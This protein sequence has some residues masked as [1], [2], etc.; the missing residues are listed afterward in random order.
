M[1]KVGLVGSDALRTSATSLHRLRLSSSVNI[2]PPA[3]LCGRGG[4]LACAPMPPQVDVPGQPPDLRNGAAAE[5]KDGNVRPA[6][7]LTG[8]PS[9]YLFMSLSRAAARACMSTC[10]RRS[11][12]VRPLCAT[13][14]ILLPRVLPSCCHWGKTRWYE[15]GAWF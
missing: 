12:A 14:R 1:A 8:I 11:S 15:L 9:S 10:L 4:K 2:E 5:K 7:M 3:F 6:P 13:S